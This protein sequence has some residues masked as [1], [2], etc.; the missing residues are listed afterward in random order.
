MTTV[1]AS[2]GAYGEGKAARLARRAKLAP[3]VT[4]PWLVVAFV[5]ASV[6]LSAFGWEADLQA[7]EQPIGQLVFTIAFNGLF[8]PLPLIGGMVLARRAR[9]E[10]ALDEGRRALH[11]NLG[12]AAAWWALMA[13][14]MIGDVF[15]G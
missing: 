7:D 2:A 14:S 15:Q 12:I 8:V 9:A 5:A 1:P 11:L 3:I 6:L 13:W 10:G 4:I